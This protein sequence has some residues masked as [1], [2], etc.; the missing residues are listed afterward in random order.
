MKDLIDRLESNANPK[1]FW[2]G[3]VSW[4]GQHNPKNCQDEFRSAIENLFGGRKLN[5]EE[6]IKN[7]YF[8]R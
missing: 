5:K 4:A 6:A 2:C 8:K 7:R 3:K 1:C